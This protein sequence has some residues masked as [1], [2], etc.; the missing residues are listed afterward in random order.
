MLYW[1]AW[2]LTY[3]L[4]F[5]KKRSI[6]TAY[7]VKTRKRRVMTHN[8]WANS[9]KLTPNRV[10]RTL[11]TSNTEIALKQY[12]GY[13]QNDNKN[14]L[15]QTVGC[16]SYTKENRASNPS[17]STVFFIQSLYIDV[18]VPW[19]SSRYF[20]DFQMFSNFCKDFT[21][22][23]RQIFVDVDP[24]WSAGTQG[25]LAARTCWRALRLVN[26][27][28]IGRGPVKFFGFG[29][30]C[31]ISVG[32]R[33]TPSL[34]RHKLRNCCSLSAE[35]SPFRVDDAGMLN[36]ES[37]TPAYDSVTPWI[38]I[39]SILELASSSLILFSSL[40]FPW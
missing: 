15:T 8:K 17:M 24:R 26:L 31:A 13:E 32:L 30:R 3:L 28:I 7:N 37:V 9:Y 2:I 18:A 10:T 25:F 5:A 23:L 14:G 12:G 39:L 11:N 34:S 4:V 38:I 1:T 16:I 20:L 21:S 27:T 6:Y 33:F 36:C 19:P 40:C 35:D 29:S 22:L